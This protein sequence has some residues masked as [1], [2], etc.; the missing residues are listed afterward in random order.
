M[1][2]VTAQQIIDNLNAR[3]ALVRA[4]GG[5][6]SEL[7]ALLDDICRHNMKITDIDNSTRDIKDLLEVYK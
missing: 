4:Q 2:K 7:Q 6:D 1:K 5:K 3:L